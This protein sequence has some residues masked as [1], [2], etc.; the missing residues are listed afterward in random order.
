MCDEEC[1]KV[2]KISVKISVIKPIRM[3][4]V[5][6]MAFYLEAV[7]IKTHDKTEKNKIKKHLSNLNIL[8]I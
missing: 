4:L 7:T 8:T 2:N 3:N 1:N 5:L 6:A